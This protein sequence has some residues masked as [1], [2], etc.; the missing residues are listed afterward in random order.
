L[1]KIIQVAP[2]CYVENCRGCAYRVAHEALGVPLPEID[3]SRRALVEGEGS[4]NLR[5]DDPR[6]KGAWEPGTISW[7]EHLEVWKAYA[8][9]HGK[10]QDAERINQRGGFGKNEAELLLGRPLTTWKPRMERT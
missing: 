7:E 3:N 6:R 9:K 4:W 1:E 8:A 5:K 2:K 10:E